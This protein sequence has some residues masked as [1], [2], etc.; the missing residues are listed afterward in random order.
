MFKRVLSA[1]LA[2][3]MFN[4]FLMGCEQATNPDDK[5]NSTEGLNKT[6]GET[7]TEQETVTEE[8]S[9]NG[10]I[11]DNMEESN[12]PSAVED[13]IME[14]Q[15]QETEEK[16]KE[17]AKDTPDTS[18][19][20]DYETFRADY[21]VHEN[22]RDFLMYFDVVKFF[23][24]SETVDDINKRILELKENYEDE[25]VNKIDITP[26]IADDY[27]YYAAHC[28]SP[29]DLSSVY[30]DEQYVSVGWHR[31]WYAGGIH[32]EGWDSVNYDLIKGEK[33]R[34]YDI[35]GDDA[36]E[37][38]EEGLLGTWAAEEAKLGDYD[39]DNLKFFF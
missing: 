16:A 29:Y 27:N 37:I 2:V 6:A 7:I 26:F 30:Y 28:F 32:N 35:L 10:M 38:I 18:T 8:E 36:Y 20:S 14:E 21:S 19:V 22:S 3:A 15:K 34:I 5:N 33:V 1:I 31:D 9:I 4:V 24:E 23:G 13:D 25:V 12:D 39:L 17:E 11:N